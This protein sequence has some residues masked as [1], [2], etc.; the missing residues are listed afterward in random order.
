MTDRIGSAPGRT[1]LLALAGGIGFLIAW[2]LIGRAQILGA[3]W[4]PLSTVL[5]TLVSTQDRLLLF[6]ALVVTVQE[7]AIGYCVGVV[8]ATTVGVLA[9][10][11]PRVRPGLLQIAVLIN[12]IPIIALGPILIAVF[13]RE[14]APTVLS[15]LA[16]FFTTLVAV[17]SGLAGTR[18]A[19]EDLM[20]ALGAGRV[21]RLYRIQIPT[22]LPVVVD[23][24]QLAAPSAVLGAILGEWFGAP[25]GIGPILVATMQDGVY[26]MLWASALTGV[27]VSIA[28]FGILALIRRAVVQRYG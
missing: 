16:V 21:T 5:S 4:P 11:L 17:T 8:V 10:L 12:A 3:A 26:N 27:A 7:A 23:A 2:E 9:T 24:L 19:H 14:V 22:A 28:A 25:D 15:A 18:S 1:P 20:K 13:P 6:N